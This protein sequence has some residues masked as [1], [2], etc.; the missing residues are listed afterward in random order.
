M[1]TKLLDREIEI[2]NNDWV[3]KKVV[4]SSII[5]Q[6]ELDKITSTIPIKEVDLFSLD[7]Y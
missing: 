5:D 1:F 7:D 4:E 3:N 2:W 6:E